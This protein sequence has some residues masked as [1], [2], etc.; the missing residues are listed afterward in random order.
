MKISIGVVLAGLSGIMLLVAGVQGSFSISSLNQIRSGIDTIV[1]DRV[2][3]FILLGKVSAEVS[4]IR[5]AQASIVSATPDSWPQFETQMQNA[6]TALDADFRQ[7][8]EY[9]VDEA[10]RRLFSNFSE[11]WRL[12][13]GRWNDVKTLL[14]SGKIDQARSSFVGEA[15]T[16]FNDA[17]TVL[18]SAVDDMENDVRNEGASTTDIAETAAELNYISLAA[19][20]AIGAAA[21]LFGNFHLAR[22]LVRMTNVMRR[23]SD[24]DS[25]IVI[26][27]RGRKDEIGAMAEAVE[28]F[29]LAAI[30]NKRL[31]AQAETDRTRAEVE[32]LAAQQKAEADADERLRAATSGLADGLKRLASGDLAFQINDVFAPD[33]ETLRHDFNRSLKQLGATLSEI[34]HSIDTMN[35]GTR[36]IAH[37]SVDLSKRT[38]QQAAT[39]EETA[40]ALDEITVNV[41]SSTKRVHEA[42]GAATE[43]NRAAKLSGDVVATAVDAMQRIEQSSRQISN[44]IVVIDEIAF[45]TNLLALNAGVEA[46]RAGEAGKGFA[47][48]AQEVRELAQRSAKAAK[49]IK[50]LISKS[51]VEVE[52]GVK[53]VQQTGE[54][55]K[56]IESHV[57]VMNEHMGAIATSAQEQATGLAELNTAV[58]QMD[59]TTQ[60]NAAMVEETTSATSALASESDKLRTLLQKFQLV[61]QGSQGRDNGSYE[62]RRAS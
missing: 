6:R 48:V 19:A 35:D 39:L 50:E 17:K 57:T 56:T 18:R 9:I 2:P 61:A 22:P 51:S 3:A 25:D 33:F 58:N 32:R 29:R 27:A 8:Q 53:L 38:E 54:A 24:G 42:R 12:A 59:Q 7:Y 13:D 55:L 10:D 36:E 37:G 41:A 20:L 47:V 31:E 43:A 45:Q 46:A 1:G 16:A 34:S 30:E 23:L 4:N 26:P 21:A 14:T 15:L 40:A 11:K 60:Q 49:E 52:N 28:I 62:M 44:I 5:D